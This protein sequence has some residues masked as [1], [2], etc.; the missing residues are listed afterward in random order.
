MEPL[1]FERQFVQIDPVTQQ[2][3]KP[4]F[5]M[6]D[7]RVFSPKPFTQIQIR[8]LQLLLLKSI[9]Q[10]SVDNAPL[11]I[12]KDLL[13]PKDFKPKDAMD[14]TLPPPPITEQVQKILHKNAS[15]LGISDD[16]VTLRISIFMLPLE[17]LE[18]M[19]KRMKLS[20][21]IKPI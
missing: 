3:K 10:N 14:Q 21:P 20:T 9:E 6:G 19:K 8:D 1:V 5:Q 15:T 16:D 17:R 7:D 13:D 12:Q 2:R 11:L 18:A 4:V